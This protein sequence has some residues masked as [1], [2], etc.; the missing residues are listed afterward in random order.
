[1]WK[2]STSF[3][4]MHSIHILG[5]R[6]FGG[7]DQFFVRLVRALH[8]SGHLVSAISRPGS[9][10][11]NALKHDLLEQVHL[12]LANR[13]DAWS[14]WQIRRMVVARQPCVVQTYM[15]RATR[16]TRVPQKSP[17]AHIA[18]LG[19]FYKIDGYYRHADAWVGNTRAIC[20][21]LVKSGMP[22]QRVHHIGNFVPEPVRATPEQTAALR[23][24]CKLPQDAWVI[25]ALG[26]LI[27]KKGFDDLFRALAR[28]PAEIQGRP[29][30][31]L[32]AGDG[33]ERGPLEVLAK[34]LGIESR[35]RLVGWQDPPDRFY[36]MAD[37]FVCPSRHEPLGNVIL[38]AW[39]HSLPVVSTRS[40][41][42]MELIEEG[43]TGLLCDCKDDAGM[44]AAIGELLGASAVAR[45]KM[46]EAGNAVLHARH[47]QD[48]IVESYLTLYRELSA[49]KGG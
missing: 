37:V 48:S 1:V 41:G 40:D 8:A 46:G 27:V 47:G 15:G 31:L 14:M 12:P 24:E 45:G 39:N 4:A 35:V 9:P 17:V 7:A 43:S 6:E 10:V 36:S 23:E 34:E 19:G 13:W 5:S 28:L 30:V 38:E 22:T 18:R 33:P 16:L 2:L 32:L 44:A 25:F 49:E 42:A 26:R 3:L 29:W 20:D 21:F 11:A